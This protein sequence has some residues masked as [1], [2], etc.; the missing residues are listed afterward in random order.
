MNSQL[1]AEIMARHHMAVELHSMIPACKHSGLL[2]CG[3]NSA[4]IGESFFRKDKS[5]W[6]LAVMLCNDVEKI[7]SQKLCLTL[8]ALEKIS[9]TGY[10]HK[11]RIQQFFSF[12]LN[13]S[14][15]S[16]SIRLFHTNPEQMS[17]ENAFEVYRDFTK[18]QKYFYLSC[19]AA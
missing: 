1:F 6:G 4:Y 10:F 13:L 17:T 9:T 11:K 12:V 14:R 2:W 7:S 8:V 18:M 19:E 5:R 15:Q 16:T 3:E